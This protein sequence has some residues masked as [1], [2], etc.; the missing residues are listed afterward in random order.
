MTKAIDNCI[1]GKI[2]R[3]NTVETSSLGMNNVNSEFENTVILISK[4]MAP[5]LAERY[6]AIKSSRLLN[7]HD[8]HKVYQS[9]V[10]HQEDSCNKEDD[11]NHIRLRS[12]N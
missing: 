9:P 4:E 7:P 3:N 6:A 10:G 8:H 11:Q 1:D 12:G 5:S 2:Y